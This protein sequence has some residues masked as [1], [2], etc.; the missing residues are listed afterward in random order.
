MKENL[1]M[2]VD[3][4]G[5]AAK[6][7]GIVQIVLFGSVASGEDTPQSDID[8]AIVH[9]ADKFS[10][11]E[12]I[13]A[14]KPSKIQTTFV[15]IRDLYKETELIGALSGEGLLLHGNPIIIRSEKTH[16]VPKTVICYYLTGLK[17]TEKV[18]LNRAL[19]GSVSKSS[20]GK[21][22]Y[23]TEVK[24]ML[25]E[26]GAEKLLKG[27]MIIPR[28]KSFKVINLLKRFKAKY[29]EIPIWCY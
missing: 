3:F 11:M 28:K 19:Y 26:A 7:K 18:K 24:G 12:K 8:I 20:Y 13:N 1:K 15:H 2:A 22:R 17:Q 27:V 9:T 16:L 21:K 23:R 4:A 29:Q 14:F 10:V 5:K 6:I 25:A